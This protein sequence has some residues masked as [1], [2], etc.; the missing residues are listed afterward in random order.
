MWTSYDK[1]ANPMW[2]EELTGDKFFFVLSLFIILL[3]NLKE[4]ELRE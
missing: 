3:K 1:H 4:S 2:A